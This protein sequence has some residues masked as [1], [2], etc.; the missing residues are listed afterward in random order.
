M[1][2]HFLLVQ[3]Y[4]HDCNR[5]DNEILNEKEVEVLSSKVTRVLTPDK[6][7]GFAEF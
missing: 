3:L 6:P 1:H 5:V 4:P 2:F 7:V